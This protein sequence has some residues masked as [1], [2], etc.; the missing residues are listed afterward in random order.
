LGFKPEHLV[1]FGLDS[2]RWRPEPAQQ[3]ALQQRLLAELETLPGVRSV[4]LG[5]A[6]MLS[7]NGINLDFTVEGYVR[8][9]DEEMRA[10]T[11]LAGPRFFETTGVPLLRGREFTPAD[12]PA[13]T[14]TGASKPGTVVILG[15]AMAR[16]YFGDADPIGRRIT[17]TGR[18]A[19]SLE[20]IG[21]ARDTRYSRNLRDRVPLEFYLPYPAPSGGGGFR[22]PATFYVR[23]EQS[24]AALA[25]VIRAMVTRLE[26][27]LALRDFRS[28]DEAIDRLL[29]RERIIAQLVGF[30]SIFALLL[31]SLGVYAVL[32]YNVAQRTREIGVRM[33]L[34]ASLGDVVR[35]VLRQG[36]GLTLAGCVLGM[37]AAFA[38]THFVASLLYGVAP[39]D[40]AT[41]AAVALLLGVVALGACWLPARRAAKVDP[42]VALRAE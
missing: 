7:G 9:P 2:G 1:T 17:L 3:R 34:G 11:I 28:M 5:G 13:P 35:G 27:R 36:L 18:N 6:G 25:P 29:V 14:T 40:P 30:F 8:A 19:A 26:P 4:A 15:E 23:V 16:K 39:A 41:F 42:M 21:V 38:A 22:M 32:A 37:G 20:I 12:E 33:A 31:A 10:A 24:A